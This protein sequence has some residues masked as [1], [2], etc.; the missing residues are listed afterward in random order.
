MLRQAFR[1]LAAV[2]AVA[3]SPPLLAQPAGYPSKPIRFLVGFTPGGTNDIVARALAIK[4]TES[5]GQTV[6]VENRP[7]ANTAIATELCARA[8]PDLSLIHISEPTRLLSI[9]Y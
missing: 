2:V 1:A 6:V 5:M 9:S 8:V 4:L 3:V 7:G